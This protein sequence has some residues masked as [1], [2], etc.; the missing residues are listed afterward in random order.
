VSIRTRERP[1]GVLRL[2]VQFQLL[3]L[4]MCRTSKACFDLGMVMMRADLQAA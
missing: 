2:Q 4:C 1:Q 3:M